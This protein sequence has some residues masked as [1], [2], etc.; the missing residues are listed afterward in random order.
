MVP[1]VS[2]VIPTFNAGR[3]FRATLEMLRAQETNY[4]VE[5]LAVDSGSTDETVPL[6]REY[7]VA[8]V[9]REGPFNH[10]RTRNQAI[11]RAHGDYVALTVQDAVPADRRWLDALV[12]NLDRDATLAGVYSRQIPRPEHNPFVKHAL[13]NWV[14]GS[15]ERR[16][17]RVPDWDDFRRLD[18]WRRQLLATFDNVGSCLRKSAWER[19]PFRAMPFGEDV[20]WALRA[21]RAGYGIAYEPA[22]AVVH[23]HDRSAWYEFKRTYVCHKTLQDLFGTH[24]VRR[25]GAVLPNAWRDLRRRWGLLTGTRRQRLKQAGHLIALCLGNQVGQYLGGQADCFS[26]RYGARYAAIDRFLSRGV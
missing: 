26:R 18:P 24:T 8:V 22:S 12:A 11:A 3:A 6:C 21:L 20:D 17:Q 13:A 14:T 5:L 15:R 10:G 4:P 1:R 16:E 7:G 25:C 23:S 2:V 19:V 9:L